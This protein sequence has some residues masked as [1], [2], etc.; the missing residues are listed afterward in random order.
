MFEKLAVNVCY[1]DV[2]AAGDERCCYYY[3]CGDGGDCCYCCVVAAAAAAAVADHF[4]PRCLSLSRLELAACPFLTCGFCV[5]SVIQGLKWFN[6]FLSPFIIVI[7]L[8]LIFSLS[9]LYFSIGF[10]GIRIAFSLYLSIEHSFGLW[11]KTK[12]AENQ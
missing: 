9:S 12:E 8:S 11:V 7:V 10:N 4:V 3:C 6:L 5:W 2:V 1:G